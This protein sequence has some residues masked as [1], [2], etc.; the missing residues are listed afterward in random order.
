LRDGFFILEDPRYAPQNNRMGCRSWPYGDRRE[1]RPNACY[2]CVEGALLEKVALDLVNL[3]LIFE[4]ALAMEK[5]NPGF[6]QC[7]F[8]DEPG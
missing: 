1:N 6:V 4:V 2:L 3:L 8:N 7:P 5:I